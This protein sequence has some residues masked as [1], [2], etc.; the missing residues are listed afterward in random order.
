MIS[1][2]NEATLDIEILPNDL[3]LYLKADG[4]AV[5]DWSCPPDIAEAL[6][7]RLT[8]A[9]ALARNKGMPEMEQQQ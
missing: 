7:A 8:A 4:L 9:A 2:A 3:R 6:A 5:A 1:H